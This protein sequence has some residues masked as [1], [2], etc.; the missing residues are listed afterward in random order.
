MDLKYMIDKD[1]RGLNF[2]YIFQTVVNWFERIEMGVA[3]ETRGVVSDGAFSWIDDARWQAGGGH[4]RSRYRAHLLF[5][6]RN[7]SQRMVM[8]VV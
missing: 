3:C 7:C 5:D 8:K 1:K 6:D 2:L 4:E